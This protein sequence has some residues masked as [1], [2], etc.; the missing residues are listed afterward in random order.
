MIFVVLSENRITAWCAT[1]ELLFPRGALPSWKISEIP[2][3]VAFRQE[4]PGRQIPRGGVVQ[5]SKAKVPSVGGRGY[6][7]FL[8]LRNAYCL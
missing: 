8:K 2:G 1:E 7:Y 3:G 5:G 6:G 4:T